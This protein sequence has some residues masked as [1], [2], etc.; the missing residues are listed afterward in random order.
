MRRTSRWR[1]PRR[2]RGWRP[3]GPR[4]AI[5]TVP[6]ARSSRMGCA[7]RSPPP[8]VAR[9]RPTWSTGVGGGGPA[10][11]PGW[12][13]RAAN[14]SCIATL[15]AMRAAELGARLDG[16]EVVVD[17]ESD[18]A[19]LL[20]ID[21]ACRPAR[22]R[23]ASP[24]G[25]PGRPCPTTRSARSSPGASSTARCATRSSA[26]SRSIANRGRRRELADRERPGR[27]RGS[28][29]VSA[30]YGVTPHG[31]QPGIGSSSRCAAVARSRPSEAGSIDPG[32]E[33]D[34]SGRPDPT[35]RRSNDRA[36]SAPRPRI[37]GSP[38]RSSLQAT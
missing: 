26:P 18:D 27:R 11:S 1:S 3:T 31:E 10:P 19:G 24:S 30:L 15:I 5:G 21:P 9:S 20:D 33:P 6:R 29:R 17:S 36:R 37:R 16:L 7:C 13:L 38:A 32:F 35:S 25:S 4:R 28:G 23:C 22:S 14:A 2:A 34:L 8:M 12:L